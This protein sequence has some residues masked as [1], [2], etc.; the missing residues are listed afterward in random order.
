MHSSQPNQPTHCSSS[1]SAMHPASHHLCTRQP[2][3]LLIHLAIHLLIHLA[4]RLHS[5]SR[6][7]P[8]SAPRQATTMHEPLLPPLPLPRHRQL[9]RALSAHGHSSVPLSS[10]SPQSHP[11]PHTPLPVAEPA[12]RRIAAACPSTT[13]GCLRPRSGRSQAG[14]IRSGLA[15]RR[16]CLARWCSARRSPS[17]TRGTASRLKKCSGGWLRLRT[18]WAALAPESSRCTRRQRA[19][20]PRDSA[21][22]RLPHGIGSG[23]EECLFCV[24]VS[25][26]AEMLQSRRPTRAANRL[27]AP[28]LVRWQSRMQP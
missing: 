14:R 28:L 15:A 12:Q 7:A 5:C 3:H 2:D 13:T 11:H 10:R 27:P 17:T 21:A 24:A 8:T 1:S 25:L 26:A 18:C 23:S 9:H 6:S 4:S 22:R 16:M 19:S 20:G